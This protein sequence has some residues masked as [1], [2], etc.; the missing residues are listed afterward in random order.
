MVALVPEPVLITPPCTWVIV[1][2]PVAGKPFNIT[3]PVDSV[4][5]G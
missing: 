2:V 3:L 5:V 4:H 1:H